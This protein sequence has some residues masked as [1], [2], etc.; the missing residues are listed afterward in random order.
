MREAAIAA[1]HERGRLGACFVHARTLENNEWDDFSRGSLGPATTKAK[2]AARNGH[3]G[4]T[5][6]L[7][8]DR[9]DLHGE[10]EVRMDPRRAAEVLRDPV[11]AYE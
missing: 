5:P 9:T 6:K 4:R 10:F 7:P 8:P 11:E 1:R 2:K 3:N